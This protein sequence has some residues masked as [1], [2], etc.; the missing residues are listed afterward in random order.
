[1]EPSQTLSFLLK[2][3]FPNR[4]CI[5]YSDHKAVAQQTA[6]KGLT[7]RDVQPTTVVPHHHPF[8]H[9]PHL[10]RTLLKTEGSESHRKCRTPR[11]HLI[12]NFQEDEL[13]GA[14]KDWMKTGRSLADVGPMQIN[15]LVWSDAMD[16]LSDWISALKEKVIFPML[17]PDVFERLKILWS[18]RNCKH[19][20]YSCPF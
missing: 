13:K 15:C 7:D 11:S 14:L 6:A 18:T 4:F 3:I 5:C 19:P 12:M 2:G 8:P 17:Y 1:M 20:G 16:G 10:M 9:R